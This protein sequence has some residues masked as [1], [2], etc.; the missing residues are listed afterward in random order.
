MDTYFGKHIKHK[1][2][3]ETENRI[4]LVISVKNIHVTLVTFAGSEIL[5]LFAMSLF[6]VIFASLMGNIHVHICDCPEKNTFTQVFV[7]RFSINVSLAF[8][9]DQMKY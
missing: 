2:D 1:Q 9:Y 4:E 6:G 5:F 3:Y 8:S 7:K